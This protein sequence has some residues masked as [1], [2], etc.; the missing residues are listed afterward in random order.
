MRNY[1]PFQNMYLR[2]NF[3]NSDFSHFFAFLID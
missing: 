1:S 3:K 2:Y